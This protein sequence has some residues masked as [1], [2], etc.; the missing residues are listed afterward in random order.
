MTR[1]QLDAIDF[2]DSDP[3]FLPVHRHGFLD[4]MS[5]FFGGI[6]IAV[7]GGA[8]AG[9]APWLGGSL[10]FAG[11]AMAASSLAG[12][13]NLFAR[14][15]RFGFWAL[16]LTGAAMAL[17]GVFYPRSTWAAVSAIADR[18]ALFLSVAALAWPIAFARYLHLKTFASRLAKQGQ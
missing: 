16:A 4:G 5:G 14:S 13:R 12:R 15:L 3:L 18:H 17:G 10:I 6:L 7:S 8:L 1:R 2:I 11:Y 9:I